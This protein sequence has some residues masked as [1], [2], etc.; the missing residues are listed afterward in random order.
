VVHVIPPES[1]L[2]TVFGDQPA[3]AQH[4]IWL[5]LALDPFMIPNVPLVHRFAILY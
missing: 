3:S 4:L 5:P 1:V 2:V